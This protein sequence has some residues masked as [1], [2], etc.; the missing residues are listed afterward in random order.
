MRK[1]PGGSV[2]P[3][4]KVGTPLH[5]YQRNTWGPIEVD[6]VIAPPGGW[7]NPVATDPSASGPC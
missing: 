6:T 4:L 2:D 7:H 3:V 1:R 5:E